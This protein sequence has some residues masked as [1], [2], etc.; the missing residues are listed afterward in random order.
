MARS[1]HSEDNNE[2]SA[3]TPWRLEDEAKSQ[4]MVRE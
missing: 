2:V 4:G 3:Q 1:W